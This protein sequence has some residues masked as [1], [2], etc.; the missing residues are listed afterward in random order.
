MM[1]LEFIGTK[2]NYLKCRKVIL[3]VGLLLCSDW[4]I[5]YTQD[6]NKYNLIKL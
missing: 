5:I 4:Q 6:K 3:V 1:T 2:K